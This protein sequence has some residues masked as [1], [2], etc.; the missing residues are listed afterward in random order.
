MYLLQVGL[1]L[2]VRLGAVVNVLGELLGVDACVVV[3]HLAQLVEEAVRLQH[4]HLRSIVIGQPAQVPFRA[5]GRQQAHCV[6]LHPMHPMLLGSADGQRNP[7]HVH[8]S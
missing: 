2:V 3:A 4:V 7:Q 5:R 6:V 1:C 8:E